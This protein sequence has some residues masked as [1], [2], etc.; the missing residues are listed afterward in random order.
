MAIF[1]PK[2]LK[3]SNRSHAIVTSTN[4]YHIQCDTANK[5]LFF[6]FK[7]QVNST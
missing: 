7:V 4:N 2:I 5:Q 3:F 6:T 1:R